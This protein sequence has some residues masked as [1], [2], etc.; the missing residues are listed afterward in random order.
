MKIRYKYLLI[1]GIFLLF[2]Y[3][4]IIIYNYFNRVKLEINN[5]NYI[6]NFFDTTNNLNESKNDEYIA[7]LEIP[8]INLKRGIYSIG[9]PLNNVDKNIYLVKE[10]IFPGSNS[11]SHIILA[12]HSG[13][14]DI[15]YFKNIKKL[16]L[17]DY[18]YF[19]YDNIRYMF[20]IVNIYE[21]N[22][23]GNIELILNNNDISLITC[24][25]ENKQVI[26]NGILESSLPF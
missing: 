19:Y 18:I 15:S 20:K 7:I 5:K 9:N 17:N 12:S 2:I 13:N 4:S 16:N 14:S 25:G 1:I 23:T 22:K 11:I 3:F 24:K 26:Y 10:S 21:V 6:N 8:K